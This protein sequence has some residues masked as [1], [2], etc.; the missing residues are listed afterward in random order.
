VNV[1]SEEMAKRGHVI[2]WTRLTR[3]SSGDEPT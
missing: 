3:V 1:I 2:K